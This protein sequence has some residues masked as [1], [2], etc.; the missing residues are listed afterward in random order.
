[1]AASSSQL[2]DDDHLEEEIGIETHNI[3]YYVNGPIKNQYTITDRAGTYYDAIKMANVIGKGSHGTVYKGF[4]KEYGDVAIK[5]INTDG[6]TTSARKMLENELF[7]LFKI[8]P[9]CRDYLL[10]I[11]YVAM[12]NKQIYLV[13]EYIDGLDMI[14]LINSVGY[15]DKKLILA[16][17]IL[18]MINAITI[19][20][21][22][23]IAH[24]D[25]KL[26]N[27]MYDKKT[28][29]IKLVDYGY[30]CLD[31]QDPSSTDNN[32]CTGDPG[33]LDYAAPELLMGI[34]SDRKKTDIWAIGI[35]IIF[36]LAAKNDKVG[37][38][39]E[40]LQYATAFKNYPNK[41][42]YP[43]YL[44]NIIKKRI[45]PSMSTYTN[46]ATIQLIQ[47]ICVTDPKNRPNING[48]AQEIRN[49]T[50]KHK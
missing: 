21:H 5:I 26:D 25:I 30:A 42:S 10:C 3:G 47:N 43:N 19:L 49:I 38:L 37:L 29:K 27:L 28:K 48:V 15:E 17:A 11:H 44:E 32:R 4:S 6:M 36:L 35:T 13:S 2:V 14:Q 9:V 50:N 16:N 12:K 41:P 46:S 34:V 1:M 8:K 7:I 22:Y 20:H 33:T 24:R 40:Y 45:L 23:N 39:R 18:C 31:I